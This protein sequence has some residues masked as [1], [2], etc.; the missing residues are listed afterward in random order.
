V[1]IARR[2]REGISHEG[3]LGGALLGLAVTTLLAPRGLQP[4]MQWVA[5]WL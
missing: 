4:L 5:R 3:H 1:L 2:R